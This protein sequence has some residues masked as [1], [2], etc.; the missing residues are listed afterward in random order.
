MLRFRTI[1]SLLLVVATPA[2]AVE[3]RRGGVAFAVAPSAQI[4]AQ[5]RDAF[6]G[7]SPR[8]V[9][10]HPMRPTAVARPAVHKDDTGSRAS[11][12]A[13]DAAKEDVRPERDRCFHILG[14]PGGG[15]PWPFMIFQL[16]RR[17]SRRS[18]RCGSRASIR[19]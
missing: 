6:C 14:L 5:R 4:E 15:H 3:V 2:E 17:R 16:R 18:R 10:K 19:R 11:G 1:L 13:E 9:D 8:R 7:E 12:H